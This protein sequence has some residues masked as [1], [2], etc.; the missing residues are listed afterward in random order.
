[1]GRQRREAEAEGGGGGGR[2]REMGEAGA[3]WLREAATAWLERESDLG[4]VG[5]EKREFWA[6]LRESDP[7]ENEG[8]L[9]V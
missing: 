8:E 7:R 5:E 1:W 2:Q 6:V 4:G 9:G 3:A